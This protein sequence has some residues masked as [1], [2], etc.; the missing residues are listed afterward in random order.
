MSYVLGMDLGTSGLKGI[1]VD[2]TGRIVAS[3]ESD[4]PLLTPQRGHSEQDP[5]EWYLAALKVFQSIRESVPDMSQKIE[6][7]SF[8]GQMHT[9]VLLD[10]EDKVLRN[11]ILWNDV[12]TTEQCEMITETLKGSLL[13]ITKNKALE[14]FTLPKL[15]WVKEY[16]PDIYDKIS[17]F[18][19][20]KDYLGFRLT[21]HKQM[22]FSDAAGTLLLDVENRSWSETILNTFSIDPEI[23]PKLVR[24]DDCIGFLDS[25]ISKVLGIEKAVK[26]FSGGADNACAAIGA[27]IVESDQAMASIGT[28]GVFLSNETRGDKSFNGDLHYFNHA[29]ADQFY[30]MGV[31]LAAGNS[32]SWFKKTFA[33]HES[34][35]TLLKSIDTIEPGSEG[36]LFTPYISGERTPYTDST[37]RGS[38][39]GMDI[40]HTRDHFTRAVLEGITFSLKDSYEIMRTHAAYPFKTIVSVG[41]G[42]KNKAW[43]QMQADIFDTPIRTLETEQGPAMGSAM[44]AAVGTGWFDDFKTCADAFVHYK[45]VY[46]P[47]EENV[48]KYENLYTVYG[49]IYAATANLN[50]QLSKLNK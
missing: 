5:E 6:G 10:Q 25:E 22:E 17:T 40:G 26:V 41:G 28:S 15:L 18:L 13:E 24:S 11:A 42:A 37:I 44:I 3:A 33:E 39:I 32:L 14:G 49:Q 38:F 36:L 50:S 35:E 30:T 34:F 19:L 20:P 45:D 47:I 8:S 12:R 16:E 7:I 46:H 9:L 29:I 23:C 21:G 48:L 4:Y 43:L 27:G 31:T 2:R 1:L